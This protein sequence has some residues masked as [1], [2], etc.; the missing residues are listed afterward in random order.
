MPKAKS[1]SKQ[2]QKASS[3]PPEQISTW[4]PRR[5]K[6]S[7]RSENLERPTPNIGGFNAGL[8]VTTDTVYMERGMS[9]G[10]GSVTNYS[11]VSISVTDFFDYT[12]F[13]STAGGV[14]Q[15]VNNYF[16]DTNQN[17]FNN[18]NTAPSSQDATFCRVRKV[19]VWVLPQKGFLTT[20]TGDPGASNATGMYSVNVQTPGVSGVATTNALA[21]DTQVTNILPQVDTKW[22]KVFT[23]DMQKT[24]K[25]SVIRP[26]FQGTNQCLFSMSIVD[27]TTGEPYLSGQAVQAGIR[28]K[29][30]IDVDQPVAPLQ[31]A[32]FVVFRNEDFGIPSTEQN[33][34]VFVPPNPSY[35]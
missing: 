20:A 33:G 29:V 5:R 31:E 13:E 21:T 25:S 24:F 2:P 18:F 8:P 1:A 35:C 30:Q 10:T 12:T 28:V 27:S 23:C 26:F 19:C 4:R 15:F 32:A 16:W 3:K 22:K 11:E 34:T 14:P 9:G 7:L 17:L 6:P